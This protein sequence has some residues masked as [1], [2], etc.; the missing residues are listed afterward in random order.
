MCVYI[1]KVPHNTKIYI[2]TQPP[3]HATHN[4]VEVTIDID[5]VCVRIDI[6]K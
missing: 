5:R 6:A 1:R 4:L 3:L 2:T